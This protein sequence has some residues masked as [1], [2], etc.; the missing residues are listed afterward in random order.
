MTNHSKTFSANKIRVEFH[1][2]TI[3][4]KD[5]LTT[6]EKF[7]AAC[8]K[9][10]IDKVVITDHNTVA[11]ALAAQQLAPELVV[12]GEEILTE[13]G[14]ILAA[15]VKE[16]IPRGLPAKEVIE[17]LREQDAFISVSHP[18]DVFR[19]GH[20]KLDALLAIKDQVNAIE[21]FNARCLSPSFNEQAAA[22]A[23]E[24]GLA[25]TVGSDAHATF[26]LGAATMRLPEFNDAAGLRK[27]LLDVEYDVARSPSWVR[28]FSRYAVLRKKIRPIDLT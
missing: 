17:R 11:G 24:H 13:D 28:L 1:S 14:E 19:K 10:G 9:K 18:F 12:V 27:S 16:E 3:Y 22:F 6:P 23:K 20:W 25:G 21:I 5:S 7:I 2:H 4:S 15:F 8:K 26:E